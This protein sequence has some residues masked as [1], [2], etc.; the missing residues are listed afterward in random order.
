MLYGENIFHFANS[1]LRI[2]YCDL[3]LDMYSYLVKTIHIDTFP[4]VITHGPEEGRY[5]RWQAEHDHMG[6]RSIY[7][8]S[9]LGYIRRFSS[10]L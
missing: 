5:K 3:G 1:S 2:A 8:V 4:S 10:V 6:P 7:A 9:L